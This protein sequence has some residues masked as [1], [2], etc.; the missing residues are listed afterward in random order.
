MEPTKNTDSLLDELFEEAKTTDMPKGMFDQMLSDMDDHLP[1]PS[2]AS[3]VS[4]SQRWSFWEAL[5]GWPTWSSL[6]TALVVGVIVGYNPPEAIWNAT[7]TIFAT[8]FSDTGTLD[9]DLADIWEG[10]L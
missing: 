5:G 3:K 4:S 1:S 6:A 8:E 9:D 2:V 10:I 7:D